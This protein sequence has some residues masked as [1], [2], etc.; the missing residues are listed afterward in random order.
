MKEYKQIEPINFIKI[1]ATLC[2]FFLHTS[3]FSAQW[4]NFSFSEKT[5]FLK[6]P[7]WGAVWIFIFISGYLNGGSFLRNGKR[8]YTFKYNSILHFYMKRFL[9]VIIPM[10]IFVLVVCIVIEPET[11]FQNK[12]LIFRVLTLT[13][14]ND[15]AS[16]NI[17]A[18][19]YI[20]T[21]AWLYLLTP[22]ICWIVHF[23]L[24]RGK[25]P[26]YKKIILY[27]LFFA[28]ALLGFIYRI[29]MKNL[30]LDW[31]QIYVLFYCNLDIYISG[32]LLSAIIREKKYDRF[33]YNVNVVL[34]LVLF[35][36]MLIANTWI[37][38]MGGD[39]DIRYLE[40]YQWYFPTIYITVLGAVI[41]LVCGWDVAYKSKNLPAVMIEKFGKITFEFYLV[42][43]MVLNC[44]SPYISADT[45]LEYHISLLLAGFWA[46]VAV[47]V[48]FKGGH[49]GMTR[50]TFER[51]NKIG[52]D[53]NNKKEK[54]VKIVCFLTALIGS[55]VIIGFLNP[56]FFEREK[57]VFSVSD[58][59]SVH[60]E[61][62]T[63]EDN[64]FT[65]M[66][67]EA[68]FILDAGAL[69][70]YNKLTIRFENTLDADVPIKLIHSASGNETD[71]KVLSEVLNRGERSVSFTDEFNT[72]QYIR[73][74]IDLPTNE[75]Y[76]LQKIDFIKK[77]LGPTIIYWNVWGVITILLWRLFLFAI[78]QFE[79]FSMHGE[80]K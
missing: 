50:L 27:V 56:F 15:P 8:T 26:A 65:N 20:C 24:D 58:F 34:A 40:F 67:K 76:S 18:V 55:A 47:A 19:W 39:T 64:S 25:K 14:Q 12:D 4:G 37:Y 33:H 23:I 75:T 9:K 16:N 53:S 66:Q 29:Y 80:K 2:V 48:L 31:S 62:Y 1:I 38:Y 46:S 10:W 70:R 7:A 52:S 49:M 41:Y 57:E 3:I 63:Q 5:W 73:L 30:G 32:I 77:E 74:Y 6:T 68:F 71:G 28:S 43:S 21:L 45:P 59:S 79:R 72:D 13:Y 42:H 78:L 22:F 35:M 61:G 36:G 44:I 54:A 51:E 11:M 17:G 60:G 69:K